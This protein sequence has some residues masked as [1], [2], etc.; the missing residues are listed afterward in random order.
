MMAFAGPEAGTPGFSEISVRVTPDGDARPMMARCACKTI[1]LATNTI[2]MKKFILSC[3]GVAALV[4]M[5]GCS[6]PAP[7]TTTSTTTM[8][9][10]VPAVPATSTTTTQ[11]Q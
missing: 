5:T 6:T 9:P 2:L 7:T 3:L 1:N 11:T 8:T 10:A 4:A